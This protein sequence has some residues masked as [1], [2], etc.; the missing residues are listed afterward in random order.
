MEIPPPHV[1]KEKGTEKDAAAATK[2]SALQSAGK[3]RNTFM[4][5]LNLFFQK[6]RE[7][8]TL[9]CTRSVLMQEYIK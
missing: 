9:Q 3:C 6:T 4:A 2:K 8:C 5:T 1:G 7:K